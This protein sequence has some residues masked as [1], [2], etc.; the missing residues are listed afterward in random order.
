MASP[1]GD[2]GGWGDSY[3]FGSRDAVEVRRKAALD[4]GVNLIATDQYE[5]LAAFVKKRN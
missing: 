4:A 3:N 2:P 1:G 5:D